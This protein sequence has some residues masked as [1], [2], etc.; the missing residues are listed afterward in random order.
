MSWLFKRLIKRTF[1]FGNF[2]D[3]PQLTQSIYYDGPV[4][5]IPAQGLRLD[6]SEAFTRYAHFVSHFLRRASLSIQ[7]AIVQLQDAK[8]ERRQFH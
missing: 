4:C 1:Q 7:H 2:P 6:L 8:F 3:L 5:Q